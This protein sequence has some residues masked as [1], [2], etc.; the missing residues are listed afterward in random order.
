MGNNPGFILA[1]R[2]ALR[3]MLVILAILV[4]PQVG[5]SPAEASVDLTTTTEGVHPPISRLAPST[6]LRDSATGES[7]VKVQSLEDVKK[8]MASSLP[9]RLEAGVRRT[10]AAEVE[11]YGLPPN[12]GV[13]IGWLDPKGPLGRAGLNIGDIIVQVDNLPIAG[14][15]DF[16]GL[17]DSLGVRQTATFYVVD[18]RTGSLRNVM[19]VVGESERFQEPRGNFFSRNVEAAVAGIKK[20]AR[21]VKEHVGHVAEMGRGAYTTVIHGLKKWVGEAEEPLVSVKHGEEASLNP[22]V[23]ARNVAA[24]P[25]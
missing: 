4:L 3:S 5:G 7:M 25:R 9:K 10:T 14:L 2:R 17:V 11:K 6:E 8:V 19:I 12:H 21:S 23:P 13:V 20:A 1:M 18:K 16:V 22:K 24:G 15:E